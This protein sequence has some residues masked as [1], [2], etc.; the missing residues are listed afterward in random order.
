MKLHSNNT[1]EI[2]FVFAHHSSS[3]TMEFPRKRKLDYLRTLRLDSHEHIESVDP[4]KCFQIVSPPENLP[5]LSL[6]YSDSLSY[7]LAPSLLKNYE[8]AGVFQ[9]RRILGVQYRSA[10]HNLFKYFFQSRKVLKGV[11]RY[12][13]SQKKQSI[14]V[15]HPLNVVS[16]EHQY[17][18]SQS[19]TLPT[20]QKLRRT[21]HENLEEINLDPRSINPKLL[22]WSSLYLG[23]TQNL[24]E[25]HKLLVHTFDELDPAT[26]PS[27]LGPYEGR[28]IGFIVERLFS[29]YIQCLITRYPGLVQ[30][31]PVVNFLP[32]MT[33]PKCLFLSN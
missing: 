5:F 1:K 22:Y 31:S 17:S 18:L 29:D 25:F 11:E 2:L 3:P 4:E 8:Y 23:P 7:F 33:K 30:T 12:I 15:A 16:L 27:N 21:F 13:L 14:Y 20:L 24:L 26:I 6:S 28:W 19:A 10:R 32:V 9:Y